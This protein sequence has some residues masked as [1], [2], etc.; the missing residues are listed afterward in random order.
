MNKD[1]LLKEVSRMMDEYPPG[2]RVWH[3]ACGRRGVVAGW[4]LFADGTVGIR[5]D[6]GSGGYSNEMVSSLSA[7]KPPAGD[8]DGD[9]EAWKDAG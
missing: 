9:G 4:N 1:K 5:V 7:T 2:V 3:K 6:Y 8:G